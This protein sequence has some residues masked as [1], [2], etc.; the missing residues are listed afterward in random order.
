MHIYKKIIYHPLMQ[1][2]G[3]RIMNLPSI[4][5]YT[6]SKNICYDQVEHITALNFK[7]PTGSNRFSNKT[8]PR[9]TFRENNYTDVIFVTQIFSSKEKELQNNEISKTLPRFF[10]VYS[11]MKQKLQK[12]QS[13]HLFSCSIFLL[14]FLVMC[15]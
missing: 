2:H 9:I 14:E 10:T 6:C 15:Y 11:R 7:N 12:G 5:F 1:T 3:T 4:L 13:L 8:N